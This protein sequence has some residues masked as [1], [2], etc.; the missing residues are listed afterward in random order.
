METPIIRKATKSDVEALA[1]TAGLAFEND[2]LI[3]WL[4]DSAEN[5]REIGQAMLK[6][7]WKINSRFDH[8]YC[9]DACQ[10]F[11]VWVPPDARHNLTE[12]WEMM[13]DMARVV[14]GTR[15]ALNQWRLYRRIGAL[16]P[17]EPHYYLSFLGVHPDQQGRGVGH[18]LIDTILQIADQQRQPCYLETETEKNVAF[19]TR[20]GYKVVNDFF[21]DDGQVHI[22]MMWRDPQPR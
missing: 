18:A 11:A 17:K 14:K 2:P 7:D 4:G 10:G 6:S 1:V 9:E 8:I 21:S 3:H 13:W 19:Y 20:H 16:H 12:F 5:R 15:R 22:W